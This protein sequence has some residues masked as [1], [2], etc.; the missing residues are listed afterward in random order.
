MGTGTLTFKTNADLTVCNGG[1]A[2]APTVQYNQLMLI[3]GLFTVAGLGNGT[4]LYCS[5]LRFVSGSI[6]TTV[7]GASTPQ[8]A[9]LGTVQTMVRSQYDYGYNGDKVTQ[10]TGTC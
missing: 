2:A 1:T 4:M 5:T 3:P 7:G 8:L 6:T 10:Y 9:E